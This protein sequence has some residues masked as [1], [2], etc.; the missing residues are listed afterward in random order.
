MRLEDIGPGK[1]VRHG[2]VVQQYTEQDGVLFNDLLFRPTW[3][4]GDIR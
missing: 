4:N 3:I 2:S 1:Y